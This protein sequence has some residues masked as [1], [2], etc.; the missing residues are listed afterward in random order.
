MAG[1]ETRGAASAESI[2]FRD[3]PYILCPGNL[4]TP[5]ALEFRSWLEKIGARIVILGA[6][7]HDHL[8]AF[9]SHLP[10]FASTA[11]ASVIAEISP[12]SAQVSGPGLIDATRLALSSYDLWR[13][14]VS[15]NTDPIVEALSAYIQKLEHLRETLRTREL[16]HQFTA[17]ANFARRLRQ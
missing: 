12:D 4:E 7:E 2:L 16:Q 15:T 3:R 5:A 8:V 14:I 1:K 10:Q 11:L 6:D 13:D 17:A 9:S